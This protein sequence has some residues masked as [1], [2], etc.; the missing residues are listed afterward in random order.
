MIRI[1]L[2]GPPGSGKGT[3]A[4]L[5]CKKFSIGHISTGEILRQAILKN[6]KLGVQAKHAIESGQLVSD[7]II[8][9]LV[10][11]SMANKHC[12]N[13][14]LLDGFPRNLPQA[15]LLQQ[16]V[17]AIDFIIYLQV[18]D[19]IIIKR[20]SGRRYHPGSGRIYHLTHNP[21]KNSQVDDI[22]NEPLIVR[23]DDQEQIISKRLLVYHQ[24]TKQIIHWY[25]QEDHEKF[26]EVDGSLKQHEIFNK[27]LDFISVNS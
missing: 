14:F 15:K 2:L 22:T 18:P 5:I 23:S 8:M 1:I 27:I 17:Q 6:T 16:H 11:E 20:L 4:E 7:N 26:L 25:Q 24:S 3:Q 10:K 9:D 19:D 21:P 12:A 13:G